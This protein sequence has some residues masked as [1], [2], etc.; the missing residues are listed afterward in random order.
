MESES[1]YV[2]TKAGTASSEMISRG[3]MIIAP[4][5]AL[6]V[7]SANPA[8]GRENNRQPESGYPAALE[9][10]GMGRDTPYFTR[11]ANLRGISASPPAELETALAAFLRHSPEQSGLRPGQLHAFKNEIANILFAREPI[12]E[13]LAEQFMA[14][15]EEKKQ[16]AVWRDY[17]VQHL[18]AVMERLSPEERR[19][20]AGLFAGKTR[21]AE[22]GIAG[23]ALIALSNNAGL[24]EIEEDDVAR[25][26]FA[27]ASSRRM[28]APSRMTALQICARHGCDK[29]L[30]LARR[31]ARK[32]RNINL[33]ASALAAIGTLGGQSDVALLEEYRESGLYRVRT[34]ARAAL[35]RL[36]RRVA[37]AG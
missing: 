13:G 16:S 22:A 27:V 23:T 29:V 36:E 8:P 15:A 37:D 7:L 28:D 19:R 21:L 32:S 17:C 11:L 6:C 26:A 31:L 4:V 20:C 2:L 10:A 24:P 18:G 12:R 35:A 5:L 3:V 33:R 9:S 25:R 14:M 1:D 30:P 34:A